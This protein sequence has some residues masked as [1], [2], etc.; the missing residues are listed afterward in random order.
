MKIHIS[1]NYLTK[2][3]AVFWKRQVISYSF[4]T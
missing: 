2:S 4:I 1:L 3:N